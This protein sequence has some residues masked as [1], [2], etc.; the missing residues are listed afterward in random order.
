MSDTCTSARLSHDAT[1][2]IRFFGIIIVLLEN[3]IKE[4]DEMLNYSKKKEKNCRRNGF[5]AVF[6]ALPTY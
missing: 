5:M 3:M 2:N 6:C 4:L 1:V